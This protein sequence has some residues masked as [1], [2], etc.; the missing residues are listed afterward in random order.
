MAATASRPEL[1]G[2][3]TIATNDASIVIAAGATVSLKYMSIIGGA[4]G[5]DG[6]GDGTDGEDGEAGQ[7]GGASQAGDDGQGG[8]NGGKATVAG[9]AGSPAL[10]NEGTLTLNH[11]AVTGETTGGTGSKGGDGGG[12]GGGGAGGDATDEHLSGGN[13]GNGAA[14]GDGGM[15]ANGGKAVAGILNTGSLTLKNSIVYG[16]EAVGGTGGAGG[17]GGAGGNGG[18]RGENGILSHVGDVGGDGGDGGDGGQGGNG[19]NAVAGILNQGSV[20]VVG[21]ALVF[22]NTAVGGDAGSGGGAGDKGDGGDA[23]GVDPAP[24]GNDGAMGKDGASGTARAGLVGGAAAGGQVSSDT[25]FYE[26]AGRNTAT[27][28]R[29][30]ASAGSGAYTSSGFSATV[31]QEGE[32]GVGSVGWQVVLGAGTDLTAADFAGG[33]IPSGTVN[34][35]GDSAVGSLHFSLANSITIPHQETFAI[36]LLSP[37]GGVLG[38]AVSTTVT[39][40]PVTTNAQT[41]AGTAGDDIINLGSGADTVLAS[42]GNDQINC[43]SGTDIVTLGS[44]DDSV[45]G[46]TGYETITCG[47]GADSITAGTGQDIFYAGSGA[48][49]FTFFLNTSKIS[50]PDVIRNFQQGLDTIDIITATTFIGSNAFDGGAHEIRAVEDTTLNKTFVYYESSGTTPIMEIKIPGLFT[51]TA[52]TFGL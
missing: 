8:E 20:T 5:P 35:T 29:T 23:E 7:D 39:L 2:F 21:A 32:P 46:G 48:D 18:N 28:G 42:T 27:E 14:G 30:V 13:G 45:F 12:G 19:G 16:T 9:F 37:S 10:I 1:G 49:S 36:E 52:S 6:N 31:L 22:D 38:S 4:D 44:G 26:Y 41:F 43:G 40:K 17:D 25:A 33:V 51:L 24:S 3:T 11:V 50:A 34:F 47:S 15:G